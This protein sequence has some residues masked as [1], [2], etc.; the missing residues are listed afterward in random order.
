MKTKGTVSRV[1]FR[2]G[3]FGIQ[4]DNKDVWYNGFGIENP[5]KVGDVIEFEYVENPGKTPGT[6]FKN[7]NPEDVKVLEASTQPVP[8]SATQLSIEETAR[9]R[10]I[11]DCVL[12]AADM[13]VAGNIPTEELIPKAQGLY[14][15]VGLISNEDK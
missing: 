13:V 7:V 3:R 2:D 8:V 1:S 10:R 15:A 5:T 14:K 9:K 12:K 6:V 11:T 4:L